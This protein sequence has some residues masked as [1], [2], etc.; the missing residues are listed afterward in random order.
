VQVLNTL[1]FLLLPD[2][3]QRH[4]LSHPMGEQYAL[5]ES[6]VHQS[7]SQVLQSA[8]SFNTDSGT[9]LDFECSKHTAPCFI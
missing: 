6:L 4:L 9:S 5:P 7:G 1:T 2:C 8:V 3:A